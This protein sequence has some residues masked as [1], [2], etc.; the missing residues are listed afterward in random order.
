MIEIHEAALRSD[1][2]LQPTGSL[3]I[4]SRTLP[5]NETKIKLDDD[6]VKQIRQLA[7]NAINA[8][9]RE[10]TLVTRRFDI[11]TLV[12]RLDC[13]VQ[14]GIVLPYEL[15]ERPAGIG[16]TTQLLGS[17]F[18]EDIKDHYKGHIG[19][20]PLVAMGPTEVS[21]DSLVFQTVGLDDR[22]DSP[23]IVRGLPD[24]VGAHENA[25]Q[26]I[27][28]SVSTIQL[29][30]DK[31]YTLKASGFGARKVI[32]GEKL[33]PQV[34]TVTKPLQGSQ[35]R[36]VY[37]YLSPEDRAIHGKRGTITASKMQSILERDTPQLRESFAPPIRL[38][39]QDGTV[40]NMILRVFVLVHPTKE[41]EV[42][43][44]AFVIRKELIVHGASNAIAG[45]VV[46]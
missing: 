40:G 6:I 45:G 38:R 26:L 19:E 8:M 27:E 12:A 1:H 25:L 22:S 28:R 24:T 33:D 14:N 10:N 36:G 17:N 41:P 18:S 37:V 7:Q 35:A 43:G 34:S 21:D 2:L 32:K 30:G 31:T 15:E 23:C 44:G 16:V 39:G 5:V 29:E 4:N 42:I 11:P 3:E 20:T 46:V 13:T 9:V